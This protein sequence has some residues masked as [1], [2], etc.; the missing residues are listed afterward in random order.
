MTEKKWGSLAVEAVLIVVSILLAFYIDAAWSA[1]TDRLEEVDLLG[2]VRA[3]LL[4]NR[5]LLDKCPHA[6]EVIDVTVGVDHG[7][8]RNLHAACTRLPRFLYTI[9]VG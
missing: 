9:P 2:D 6:T 4:A 3:E 1:R 5:A 7:R 8:N